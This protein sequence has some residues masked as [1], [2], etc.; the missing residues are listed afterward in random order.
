VIDEMG[1]GERV[2]DHRTTRSIARVRKLG[3]ARVGHIA[4]AVQTSCGRRRRQRAGGYAFEDQPSHAHQAQA[5]ARPSGERQAHPL[6]D[7]VRD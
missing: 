6:I 3:L 4:F 2:R 5:R 7:G 1:K